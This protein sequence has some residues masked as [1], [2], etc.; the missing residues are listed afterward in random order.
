M[1]SCLGDPGDQRNL[2]LVLFS[3]KP[4]SSPLVLLLS[5]RRVLSLTR[6]AKFLVAHQ[7]R[8]KGSGETP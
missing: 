5:S 1:C 3:A 6:A 7:G 2:T 4:T 8:C